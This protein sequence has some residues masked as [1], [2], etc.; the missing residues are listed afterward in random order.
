MLDTPR[1]KPVRL[2]PFLLLSCLL[3]SAFLLVLP[4]LTR[5]FNIHIRRLVPLSQIELEVALIKPELESEPEPKTE[6]VPTSESGVVK[7]SPSLLVDDHISSKIDAHLQEFSVLGDNALPSPAPI[8]LPS[9]VTLD[10]LTA[11]T[12]PLPETGPRVRS[13]E[14]LGRLGR[15]ALGR[16]SG[17][18][19]GG[20]FDE[21]HKDPDEE[22]AKLLLA[23]AQRALMALEAVEKKASDREF[24]LSGPVAVNRKVLFRP[25]L[26]KVT[27]VRDVAVSFRFWVRPDGSVSRVEARRIGDLELVNVAERFLKQWR[28]SSL[29][30][31]AEP[32]E[33]WGTV[34]VIFRVPR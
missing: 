32:L 2:I 20:V 19:L 13:Q 15:Q 14:L 12:L 21:G 24:G 6:S 22:L 5:L 23:D 25:A 9:A 3:H 34:K 18:R 4:D 7:V 10:K 1:Y 11:K 33:Q 17:Q 26:P 31:E 29:S 27:L 28:F 30:S 8:V 16:L